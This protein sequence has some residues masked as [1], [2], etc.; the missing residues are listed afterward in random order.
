MNN[1]NKLLSITGSRGRREMFF[2]FFFLM[3][4]RAERDIDN[5]R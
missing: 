4:H 2:Y 3:I 5:V 1:R